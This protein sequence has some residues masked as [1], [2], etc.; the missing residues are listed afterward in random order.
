RRREHDRVTYGDVT[1]CAANLVFRPS[2][3]HH[4]RSAGKIRNLE[5]DLGRAVALDGDDAG[6]ERQGF[7]RRGRALQFD[8]TGIAAGLDLAA[9]AWH[10]VDELT[11]E[12][13]NVGG[14]PTLAEVVV[15]GR[16]RPVAGQV[17]DADIDRGDDDARLLA[18][19]EPP[20]FDRDAQ[21][22]IG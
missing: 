9:C 18:R 20:D 14:E 5:H 1:G 22:A 13:A 7:L 8:R 16:R 3:R 11:V 4:A 17:Q 15:V 6:I 19:V 10:A 2:D 21:R 12:V